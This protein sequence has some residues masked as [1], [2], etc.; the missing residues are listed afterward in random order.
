MPCRAQVIQ[1]TESAS[2]LR[3]PAQPVVVVPGR[4]AGVVVEE[5]VAELMRQRPHRLLIAD[6]RR[7]ADAAGGPEDG[8]VGR[9]P[10][11]CLDRVSLDGGPASTAHPRP[12]RGRIGAG[13]AAARAG[14]GG[15]GQVPEVGDPVGVSPGRPG[16]V[17]V[18]AGVLCAARRAGDGEDRDAVLAFADLLSGRGPL[19][20][21]AHWVA[22][23]RWALMSRMFPKSSPGSRAAK[24]RQA[25][26]SPGVR[27][28]SAAGH[29]GGRA[30][31]RAFLAVILA[32]AG[33]GGGAGASRVS[34]RLAAGGVARGEIGGCGEQ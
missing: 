28:A 17:V 12:G 23:G 22:P 9:R 15:L 21:V 30:A 34:G 32:L 5:H 3:R 1:A 14:P 27:S 20:V 6:L 18:F 13:Q 2:A 16:L 29:A 19:P 26:Q 11:F 25:P 4:V 31:R 33:L 7:D 10:V 8:P 24:R